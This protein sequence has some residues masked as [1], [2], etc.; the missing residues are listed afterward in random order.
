V[1]IGQEKLKFESGP[2]TNFGMNGIRLATDQVSQLN[3]W[4]NVKCCSKKSAA[5]LSVKSCISPNNNLTNGKEALPLVNARTM[6]SKSI[7]RPKAKLTF[8]PEVEKMVKK[9]VYLPDFS[10]R[11][12]ETTF[13]MKVNRMT[14]VSAFCASQA[15]DHYRHSSFVSEL[16]NEI[17]R[18]TEL[19]SNP[20]A[21]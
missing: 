4:L 16:Q 14:Y 10:L 2:F 8:P 18:Q 17:D 1:E 13:Y 7:M 5:E 21:S 6:S 9:N 19:G 12:V 20:L 11:V 15:S 3:Q